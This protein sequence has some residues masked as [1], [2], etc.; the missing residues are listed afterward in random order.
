M[1]DDFIRDLSHGA[2]LLR[3]TPAFT[4]VVLATLGVA[5]GA[6]V[7]V[8]SIVDAWLFRPLSF[9][10]ANRLVVAFGARPERP[11]EPQVW[12]PYRAYLGWKE[13]SR[14]FTSLSGA[15]VREA[16]V[17]KEND[18]RTALGLNVTAEFFDTLR[19]NAWLGRTLT[20]RDVGGPH[21]VVL[22]H[23]FWQREFGGSPEAIGRSILL[24]GD[25]HEVV[26]IMPREFDL[27][28][29]DM[30]F[31]FYTPFTPGAAGYG[32]GGA[33]PVA[34]IGRLRHGVAAAAAQS[35][36]SAISREIEAGYRFN[37]NKFVVALASLQADN[38]RNVRA[39]LLTVSAAV[40]SLLLIAA[41]NVGALLL[42]RSLGRVRE[43]A[44][45]VAIGASRTR[46]V[47]QLLTESLL[48]ATLGGAIGLALTAAAIRLFVA[49]NPLG[50]LPANPI[51]LDL[52]V[53][54]VTLAAVAITTL[55]AG[56]IPAL[57]ASMARPQDGLLGGGERGAVNQPTQRA[58][59][60]LLVGQMAT[61][62]VLLVT[63][64]LLTQTFARL[65]AES[66]GFD[67]QHLMIAGVSLPKAAFE[68]SDKRNLYYQRLADTVRAIPSVRSVAAS[69]ARPLS[70][71]GPTTVNTGPEDSPDAARISTQDVTTEF[72]ATLK[73]PVLAG[74]A[75]DEH[76]TANGSAV[77]ALNVRAATDLFGGPEQ[78]IGR[79][80]RLDR[81][82]W[83]E[84]VGIVGGVR[85]TFFN[86]LE[87]RS[88]PIVYRPAAQSFLTMSN[89]AATSFG[90]NLHIRSDR[91]LSAAEV[92][93][94]IRA[95]DPAALFTGLQPVSDLLDEATRQPAF[96]MT[97]LSWF[98]AVSLLLAAIGVYGLVSQAVSQ[99]LREVA[100]RLALGARRGQLIVALARR[101]LGAAAAGVAIGA[102]A[103]SMLG[104][105]MKAVLYGVQPRDAMPFVVA[106]VTLFAVT[107]VAAL[108]PARRATRV[109][110]AVT[111][112]AE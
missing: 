10:E 106:A 98:A 41:M 95:A 1:I 23:G 88:D 29:L 86:T 52:R 69:S 100:I 39:T 72:F 104:A 13:R 2:R 87:W 4:A 42:G 20:A 40:A 101:P 15:F 28:L 55:L 99:R 90:F 62:V 97:L 9:P 37:F 12:M 46:L 22:S 48:I 65:H 92:R 38:T 58:Q 91:V 32:T 50:A 66:L 83:R 70:N 16:T 78:A 19:V 49:W 51:R 75:F 82:S 25:P 103:A 85:S 5:I 59:T 57:K 111:L 73:I 18:G 96:R 102:V 108:V 21:V 7:T 89:P 112:R 84:V 60:A 43:T 93:E 61:C 35:E 14:S 74:R 68:S 47:R 53:M 31:E 94:A 27:R 33:G 71:G 64:A 80:V 76:D 6:T 17:T 81:E 63:T 54:T 24:S 109:D 44:I 30:T 77:V 67:P 36:V 8:F 3:R 34:L 107:A 26:G 79:R 56:L 110:P 11:T 105:T 45:R